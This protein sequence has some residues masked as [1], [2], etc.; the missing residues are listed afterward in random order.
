MS[1]SRAT[2]LFGERLLQVEVQVAQRAGGDEAV[3]V[4]VDRV[5]E[6][7]ARLHQR[8]LLV[9]RDDREAAA[10]ARAGVLDHGAAQRVDQL[11]QVIVARVLRVDPQARRAGARCSS[12]R[13]ARPSGSSSG[14]RT[15]ARSSSRPISSTSSQRKF[16]LVRARPGPFHMCSPSPARV[17]VDVRAVLGVRVQ[18]LLALALRALAGRADVHHQLAPSTC[19]ASANVRALSVSAS[20]WL[21]SAITPAPQ[22]LARS[23]STS[24]MSEQRRDLSHRAVQL[25]RKAAADAAGPVGDLHECAPSVAT[26]P[27]PRRFR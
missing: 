5:A 13:T 24:S 2:T 8:G 20:S 9:H 27:R 1:S 4:G 25:G 21:C 11:L 22:Q 14:R 12:R 23:S 3:G 17:C 15:F 6:V 10:L 7:A 16:L 19:C 26:A 18:P